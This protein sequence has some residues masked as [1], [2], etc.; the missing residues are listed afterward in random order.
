MKFTGVKLEKAFTELLEIE[1]YPHY[2]SLR[3]SH[4]HCQVAQ[5]G[6]QTLEQ[7]QYI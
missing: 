2:L 3:S 5:A 6:K 7:K 1:G 4:T